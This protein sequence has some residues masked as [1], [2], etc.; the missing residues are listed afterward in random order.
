MKKILLYLVFALSVLTGFSQKTDF[1]FKV[2]ISK[3]VVQNNDGKGWSPLTSGAKVGKG[4]KIKVSNGSYVG[5]MHSSGKTLELKKGGT[6]VVENLE[7]KLKSGKTDFTSKYAAFV[8]SNMKGEESKE[9]YNVTG[10]VSRGSETILINAPE[11]FKILQS[12]PFEISWQGDSS[13]QYVVEVLNLFD[14]SFWKAEVDGVETVVDLNFLHLSYFSDYIIRVTEKGK[15][16]NTD[17]HVFNLVP[18]EEEGP[19]TIEM[20]HIHSTM[21]R[22]SPLEF[23]KYAAFFDDKGLSL[24]AL[25]CLRKAESLSDDHR[26]ITLLKNRYINNMSLQK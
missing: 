10:S 7:E 16:E 5:L 11:K 2:L 23:L 9:R 14:E 25:S 6:Y 18:M 13:K 3:G 8:L 1:S 24:Y 15:K 22:E 17:Q 19:I 4:S 21:D 20:V 12:Q 26:E